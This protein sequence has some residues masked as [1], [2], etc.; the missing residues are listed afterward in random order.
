MAGKAV[1]WLMLLAPAGCYR[2]ARAPPSELTKLALH[3]PGQKPVVIRTLDG[4]SISVNGDFEEARVVTED[5]RYPLKPPFRA[6][7]FGN[8]LWYVDQVRAARIDGRKITSVE[9]EQR[10]GS[11][12]QTVLG[13]T[14]A[15]VIAGFFLGLY[16]D[17]KAARDDPGAPCACASAYAPF[18]AGGFALAISIPLTQYY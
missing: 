17:A 2:V 6:Q 3:A 1:A 7:W 4:D 12:T 15:A 14:G 9:V 10:D 13:V 8:D 18:L 16:V 5:E 11:R